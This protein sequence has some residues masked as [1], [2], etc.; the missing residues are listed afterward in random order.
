MTKEDAETL[1]VQK[2]RLMT[3]KIAK[4]TLMMP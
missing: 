1:A 3:K 2:M 4:K